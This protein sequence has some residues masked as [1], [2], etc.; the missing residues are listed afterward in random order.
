[1]GGV[2]GGVSTLHPRGNAQA[3]TEA[4]GGW[5]EGDRRRHEEALG[6]EE[7]EGCEDATGRAEGGRRQEG[8]RKEDG[9]DFHAGRGENRQLKESDG[10]DCCTPT[11]TNHSEWDPAG[12]AGIDAHAREAGCRSEE[13]PDRTECRRR[14]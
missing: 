11:P 6:A 13:R 5:Q 14:G 2:Q 12:S 1:M 10:A 8:R 4:V 7:G 3:K 9:R